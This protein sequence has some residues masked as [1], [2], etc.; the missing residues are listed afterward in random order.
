ME[1]NTQTGKWTEITELRERFGGD[2]SAINK[3]SVRVYHWPEMGW[4]KLDRNL[5][6]CPPCYHLVEL[7][8]DPRTYSG[9]PYM[10]RVVKVD[11]K[12][13]FGDGL[14]WTKA[15]AMAM[16]SIHEIAGC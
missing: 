15:E 12:D 8:G 10:P 9:E 3:H 4:F 16:K 14:P 2:K 11:Q 5:S 13:Y 1:S 7:R 6:C